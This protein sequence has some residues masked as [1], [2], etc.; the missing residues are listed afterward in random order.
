MSF[1]DFAAARQETEP[2]RETVRRKVLA[3]RSRAGEHFLEYN[4]S[5]GCATGIWPKQPKRCSQMTGR[6]RFD[7][8]GVLSVS[9]GL[10]AQSM[11]RGSRRT[12]SARD[13]H[14]GGGQSVG[15]RL[16]RGPHRRSR[17]P[18]REV[19]PCYRTID[20]GSTTGFGLLR[21]GFVGQGDHALQSCTGPVRETGCKNRPDR[22]VPSQGQAPVH[23]NRPAAGKTSGGP[24]TD[25][26]RNMKSGRPRMLRPTRMRS[27]APPPRT[28]PVAMPLAIRWF[29]PRRD[30]RVSASRASS[31]RARATSLT[32]GAFVA[33]H[34]PK[35]SLAAATSPASSRFM[36]AK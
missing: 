20:P 34:F 15:S 33:T 25:P 12:A 28:G 8:P 7:R 30:H 2:C 24:A 1:L 16:A 14:T 26:D 29:A 3:G 21:R 31:A 23:Q 35:K 6:S 9:N 36:P 19:R 22:I 4:R 17:W 32:S 5:S 27:P 18:G 11:S 13:G 10:K